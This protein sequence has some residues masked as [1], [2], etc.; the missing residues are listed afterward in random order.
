MSEKLFEF[1]VPAIT[2]ATYFSKGSESFRFVS[3]PLKSN[4]RGT[5]T[6][7]AGAG[8]FAG[9]VEE[10]DGRHAWLL[11]ALCGR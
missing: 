2:I 4:C 8:A 9:D 1:G 6:Y 11:R 5:W 7:P 10:G 3:V